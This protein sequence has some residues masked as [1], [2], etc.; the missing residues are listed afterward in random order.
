MFE[1]VMT[2]FIKQWAVPGSLRV[3]VQS[4][5][6]EVVQGDC[7][8]NVFLERMVSYDPSGLRKQRRRATDCSCGAEKVGHNGCSL[9]SYGKSSTVIPK[10]TQQICISNLHSTA[11]CFVH[12]SNEVYN[13]KG[14][15]QGS[16]CQWVF[17]WGC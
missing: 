11:L 12:P 6:R 13:A 5:R 14:S 7:N 8:R 16:A 2:L 15:D 10:P 3:D 4:A 1:C 17:C 9:W